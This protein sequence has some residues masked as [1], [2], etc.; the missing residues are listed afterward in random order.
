MLPLPLPLP[1]YISPRWR[2]GRALDHK[3]ERG[4]GHEKNVTLPKHKE[5]SRE[6]PLALD[7][8]F[9]L[10]LLSSER[11][12]RRHA[13]LLLLHREILSQSPLQEGRE[14]RADHLTMTLRLHSN[15]TQHSNSDSDNTATAAT[16]HSNSD[17][18]T[19]QQWQ[20]QH[21]NSDNTTQHNTTQQQQQWQW[22]HSNS[23]NT[24]QHSNSNSD[25][26]D[27]ATVTVTTQQHNT[28]QHS[29][30][31]DTAT[32]TVIG[33]RGGRGGRG[34]EI[35]RGRCVREREEEEYLGMV[36]LSL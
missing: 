12:H 19:Q 35:E 4:L 11:R 30:S 32:V 6:P 21:S 7:Q 34:S 36:L 8:D 16:Q 3:E 31:G 20:W 23:D 17:N 25:S 28:T 27:T 15:T 22:Q 1:W 13:L 14:W 9:D 5:L 26:G 10:S 2:Y 33:G 18:T 29:N 24:T